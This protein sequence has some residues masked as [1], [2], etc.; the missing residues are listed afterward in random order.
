MLLAMFTPWVGVAVPLELY[1]GTVLWG[2]SRE[3]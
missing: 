2:G 3:E 1:E